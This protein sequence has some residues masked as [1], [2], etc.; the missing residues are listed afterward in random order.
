[1][2]LLLNRENS[3]CTP[4]DVVAVQLEPKYWCVALTLR[5]ALSVLEFLRVA[6]PGS[7]SF[8]SKISSG[9]ESS[10]SSCVYW[11]IPPSAFSRRLCCS[12]E[13]SWYERLAEPMSRKTSSGVFTRSRV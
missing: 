5:L 10:R 11:S 9:G 2:L 7:P 4:A 1:M 8:P 6:V 3:R 12:D 13:M